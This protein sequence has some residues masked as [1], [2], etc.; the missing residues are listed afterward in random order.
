[1]IELED[2]TFAY[3]PRAPSTF[4]S[5][6]YSFAPGTLTAVTG[7]SGGGKSTLLYLLGLMLTPV[8]GT[9]RI[10]GT[11]TAAMSDGER[12]SLRARHIGFVFQDAVLDPSRTVLD[13]VIE[14]ALFTAMPTSVARERAMTLLTEL[15]VHHR[16]HHRPGEISGGQAQRVALCRA[17]LKDPAVILADEPSG[18]LDPRSADVVWSV[19]RE[20]AAA[21][22]TVI[23]ATHDPAR[24]P[25]ADRSLTL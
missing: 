7:T 10:D 14:G 25:D 8:S 13:N 21:G 12:A 22:A 6:S 19:L 5:L 18:N 9:V 20:R 2:L 17:L 3:S 24:V 23:V 16:H 11:A 1:M 15:G 4:E